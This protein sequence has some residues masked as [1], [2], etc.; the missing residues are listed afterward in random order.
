MRTRAV[1]QGA[2]LTPSLPPPNARAGGGLIRARNVHL[3]EVPLAA[4]GVRL[5]V[6]AKYIQN[7]PGNAI[8]IVH[9]LLVPESQDAITQLLQSD[10]TSRVDCPLAE[11]RAPIKFDDQLV[12]GAAEIYDVS[13]DGMLPP[14][15]DPLQLI[16]PKEGPEPGL[17]GRWRPPQPACV[18]VHGGKASP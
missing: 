16:A 17:R 2:S 1:G 9:D 18:A 3:G 5:L 8:H 14:K 7:D 15:A 13:A 6:K 4:V 10:R 12:S 11:M